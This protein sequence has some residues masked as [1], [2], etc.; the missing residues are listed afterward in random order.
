M[1]DQRASKNLPKLIAWD[2]AHN[3]V[4]ILTFD[5]NDGSPGNQITTIP[6]GNVKPGQYSRKITHYIVLHTIENVFG[7][8]ASRQRQV[9]ARDQGRREVRR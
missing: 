4:L 7:F 6:A 3:G 8:T 2:K 9:G 5:E 1:G